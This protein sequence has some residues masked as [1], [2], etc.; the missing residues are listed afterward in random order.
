VWQLRNGIVSNPAS[1]DAEFLFFEVPLLGDFAL[2][3]ECTCFGY[4]DTHPFVAGTWVAPTWNH[5]AFDIGGLSSFR[6]NGMFE[7]K[8]TQV[9]EWL[10][11]RI[12]IKDNVCRRYVN[13]RFIHEETLSE[14]RDPWIAIRSPQYGRGNVRDIRI[15]G[16]PRIPESVNLTAIT[17]SQQDS[18][19][20]QL[21]WPPHW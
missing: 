1:H 10:R 3:C 14:D 4:K 16:N 17:N 2:E 6:P 5:S 15:T 7:P 20:S 9:D 11:Y 13:G 19:A 8:L 21:P 12:E 18:S